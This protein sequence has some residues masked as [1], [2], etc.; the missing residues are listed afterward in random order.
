MSTI[1]G[2]QGSNRAIRRLEHREASKDYP[3]LDSHVRD[4]VDDF[5]ETTA[6]DDPSQTEHRK[7]IILS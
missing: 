5:S 1:Q 6:R 4:Y 2:N 3:G 7:A